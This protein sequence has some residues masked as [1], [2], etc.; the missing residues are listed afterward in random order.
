MAALADGRLPP[1][2]VAE[3]LD[4]DA[5]AAEALILA[6]RLDTGAPLAAA[7][8]PPLADHFGWALA[9]ELVD[10]TAGRPDRPHDPRPAALERAVPA[11]RLTG[12]PERSVRFALTLAERDCYDAGTLLALSPIEC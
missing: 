10:V 2:G 4:P 3:P 1:G 9:A 6:L 5:A 12:R 7:D 8:E 11:A